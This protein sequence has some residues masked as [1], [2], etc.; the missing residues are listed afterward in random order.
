MVVFKNTKVQLVV[1]GLVSLSQHV[2]NATIQLVEV[3]LYNGLV[4]EYCAYGLILFKQL[5]NGWHYAKD[6]VQTRYVYSLTES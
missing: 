5:A 3:E 4:V 2:Q 1:G 6:N